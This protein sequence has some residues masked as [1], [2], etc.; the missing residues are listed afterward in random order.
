MSRVR[1]SHASYGVTCSRFVRT[2]RTFSCQSLI[3]S[4]VACAKSMGSGSCRSGEICGAS[5]TVARL[6]RGDWSA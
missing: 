2:S 4:G 3:S 5:S 1:F 6:K